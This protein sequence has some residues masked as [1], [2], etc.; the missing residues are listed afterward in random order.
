MASQ[1]LDVP[2]WAGVTAQPQSQRREPPA[3][4]RSFPPSDRAEPCAVGLRSH[5]RMFPRFDRRLACSVAHLCRVASLSNPCDVSLQSPRKVP[6][7]CPLR[8]AERSREAQ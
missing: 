3:P 1:V 4:A 2:A 5:E 8:Q 6:R 7:T